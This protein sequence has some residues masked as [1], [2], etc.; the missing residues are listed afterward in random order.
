MS[1]QYLGDR[2]AKKDITY[3]DEESLAIPF[4]HAM[5]VKDNTA[6]MACGTGGKM[7]DKIVHDGGV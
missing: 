3:S 4:V 2:R 7:Q 5:T 6:Y 1:E